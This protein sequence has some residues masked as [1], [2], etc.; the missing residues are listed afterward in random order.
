VDLVLFFEFECVRWM[1]KDGIL[2]LSICV[3]L[4][5]KD[6]FPKLMDDKRIEHLCSQSA[7]G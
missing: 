1:T 7:T 3:G 4:S 5:T 2:V 6:R